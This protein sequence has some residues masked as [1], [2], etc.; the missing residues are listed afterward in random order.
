MLRIRNMPARKTPPACPGSGAEEVCADRP[1]LTSPTTPE[2]PWPTECLRPH[3]SLLGAAYPHAA[4]ALVKGRHPIQHRP[5]PVASTEERRSKH[6]GL[7]L[8][9]AWSVPNSAEALAWIRV[10]TCWTLLG[11]DELW[12]APMWA[13]LAPATTDG[14]WGWRWSW[15]LVPHAPLSARV[16]QL[17]VVASLLLGLVGLH[18]RT[19][20]LVAAPLV[21]WLLGIPQLS[22][23]TIHH[24]LMVWWL[25]ILALTPCADALAMGPHRGARRSNAYAW[26]A[27]SCLALLG[28]VYLF[29]GLWK[30][31]AQ[32]LAWT[33]PDN[34]SLHMHHA[35]LHSDRNA[36]WRLDPGDGLLRLGGVAALAW[37]LGVVFLLWAP[38]GRRV[39]LAGAL[40]FHIGTDVIFHIR[41]TS[42][43]WCWLAVLD[44]RLLLAG[45]LRA[46][47]ALRV[48]PPKRVHPKRLGVRRCGLLVLCAGVAWAGATRKVQ[49]WP[50]ACYPTFDL[51]PATVAQTLR[52]VAVTA[53]GTQ[54]EVAWRDAAASLGAN[55]TWVLGQR[56]LAGDVAARQ[57]LVDTLQRAGR[58]PEDCVEL[59]M[60]RVPRNMDRTGWSLPPNPGILIARVPVSH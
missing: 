31:H 2:P 6:A 51:R 25:W 36:Q 60:E 39:A 27:G 52:V 10:V 5:V 55:R 28:A 1:T 41:F 23:T 58:L 15:D 29:P 37:E 47:P 21:T 57:V 32:G 19:A 40:L 35:W 50:L 33:A 7:G 48:Q 17:V 38:W 12:R 13:G 45:I 43:L 53:S 3:G 8:L 42:L 24:H 46:L 34:L 11:L 44:V 59:R 22:G 56:V 54:A 4:N 18:A 9:R 49:G 30:L 20:L 16:V 14:P 26:G